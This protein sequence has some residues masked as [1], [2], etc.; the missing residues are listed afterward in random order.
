MDELRL[1]L[2]A[3]GVVLIVGVYIIGRMVER[4]RAVRVPVPVPMQRTEPRVESTASLARVPE[5]DFKI[6]L[7]AD[8]ELKFESITLASAS[9]LPS[10]GAMRGE[11]KPGLRESTPPRTNN[12][13]M[14]F[15]T[16]RA[17]T[18]RGEIPTPPAFAVTKTPP[19]S[20]VSRPAIVENPL[21]ASPHAPE[22][23]VSLTLMARDHQK[24]SGVAL[25]NALEAVGLERAEFDIYHF[26]DADAE[27][28]TRAVFSVANI[29]K[30]GTFD[31]TTMHEL[32]TPGLALFMQIP[33]P[34]TASEAFNAMLE[35]VQFLAQRLHGIVGDEHRTPLNPQRIRTLRERTLNHDFSHMVLSDVSDMQAP[36]RPQ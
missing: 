33:G 24:F 2:I 16:P 18:A 1:S 21:Q 27:N 11:K 36:R 7:E 6:Q 5:H 8:E 35:K 12:H 9:A 30:P 19:P 10:L 20:V 32:T 34:M 3:V 22:L 13:R 4:S 29:V 17:K 14:D 28:D 25:Y 31:A 23:I 26:R 15:P